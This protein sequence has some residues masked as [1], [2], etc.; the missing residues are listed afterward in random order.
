MAVGLVALVALV[1]PAI[2]G[3]RTSASWH[4]TSHLSL[5]K[6]RDSKGPQQIRI[7]S[8]KPGAN[9]PDIAPA[10]GQYPMWGLTSSM[11]AH[12]GA[13]AGV[14]GDFGTSRGQPQHTLMIDGELWT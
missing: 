13:I 8:L 3:T 4:L 5:K 12:S 9:V 11:S 7:L 1:T 2:A 6:V 10:T 14:N